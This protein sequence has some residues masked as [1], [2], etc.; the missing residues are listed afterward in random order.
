MSSE[1]QFLTL[2]DAMTSQ[3]DNVRKSA[4]QTIVS[5]ASSNPQAFVATSISIIRNPECPLGQSKMTVILLKRLLYGSEGSETIYKKLTPVEQ[6]GLR[7]ELLVIIAGISNGALK[8]LMAGLVGS[9]ASSLFNDESFPGTPETKWPE[10][11]PHLFELYQANEGANTNAVFLI[12]DPIFANSLS[13][14]K[15]YIPEFAKLFETAFTLADSK[16][17]LT[18]T[19]AFVTF[20]QSAKRKELKHVKKMKQLLQNYVVELIKTNEEEDL[21]TVFGYIIDISEVEPSFFKSDIDAW[22]E[23]ASK[24]RGLDKDSDSVFKTQGIEFLIPIF[25]AF[26]DLLSDNVKR[27]T[28]VT[29]IIMANLLEIGDTVEEEWKNP[30][31]GFNDEVEEQDDQKDVKFAISIVNQLFEIVGDKEMLTF[32]TTYLQPFVTSA[33][34]KHKHAAIMVLS[35]AGEYIGDNDEYMK[36]IVNFVAAS[37]KDPSPRVRYACCHLFGQFADDL[38]IKFQ[39]KFHKEY[40]GAI[41]PLLDDPVPRVVAHCCASLTNFLENC[42]QDYIAPYFEL[43]YTKLYG[44]ILNGSSFVKEAGLSAM[45]GLFE[46]ASN[47]LLNQI[48]QLM[49]IV[50]TVIQKAQGPLL[51]VLKGNAIECGTIICKYAPKEYFEKHADLLVVEMIK[52]VQSDVSLDCFDPQ[53]SFLLSGFNRLAFTIPE[54]LLPHLDSLITALFTMAKHSIVEAQANKS[55]SKTSSTEETELA[56]H[57][58]SA[59]I[60]NLSDAM[61]KYEQQIYD[62]M[63]AIID[64]IYEEDLRL[65]ALDVLCMLAKLY[66]NNPSPSNQQILRQTVH[67]LWTLIEEDNN[68]LTITD[69]ILCMQKILK[70]SENCFT[71]QELNAFFDKSKDVIAKSMKR[72]SEAHEDIDEDDDKEEADIALEENEEIEEGLQLEVANFIGCIFRSHTAISYPIFTRALN[73]LITPALSLP[74]GLKFALFLIC[75]SIAYLG[76]HIPDDIIVLFIKTFLGNYN[77]PNLNTRQSCVYG[78][79][80]AALTFGEK[81]QPFFEESLKA[82]VEISTAPLPPKSSGFEQK[83]VLENCV[84]A[85]GKI[86]KAL[87]NVLSPEIITKWLNTWLQGLPLIHD[88]KEGIVNL[89]MLIQILQT[90][91]ETL[92]NSTENVAKICEIFATVYQKKKISNPEID[93]NIKTLILGFLANEQIKTV[94]TSANLS[95]STKEF[96]SNIVKP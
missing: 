3:D 10:L 28:D 81:F 5:A 43:L 31:E 11:I 23:I 89:E 64:N 36:N 79:G 76:K 32:L 30:P 15:K 7:R 84:S 63:I 13:N 74:Q 53:K 12:L 19:E 52:V 6:E 61:V 47:L 17:K 41:L 59:F 27:L 68:A 49:S 16:T 56:L 57:M 96:I 21:E 46:G 95:E 37:A 45:S 73:E 77:T 39:E 14:L 26:P 44:W 92:L 38:Q 9:L 69:L 83:S 88:H 67:K 35:Q 66:K 72:K 48:D 80:L 22:I 42:T 25:E 60:R 91:A 29:N 40:F 62:L 2:V 55:A 71:E 86:I 78:I 90:K 85:Q 75:D 20:I 87:W 8:N 50:F 24:I 70:Y 54:K 1:Q 33:D 82:I 58:I 51:K 93:T 18:A 4:E 94:I 34:W 65:T